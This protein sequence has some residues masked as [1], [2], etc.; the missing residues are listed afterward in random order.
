MSMV[1]TIWSDS[2]GT[3]A[4][5]PTSAEGPCSRGLVITMKPSGE[6]VAGHLKTVGLL[7]LNRYGARRL[8]AAVLAISAP[9]VWHWSGYREFELDDLRWQRNTQPG[10]CLSLKFSLYRPRGRF[11][12]ARLSYQNQARIFLPFFRDQRFSAAFRAISRLW[13]ADKFRARAA[14]PSFPSCCPGVSTGASSRSSSSSPVAIR[15]TLTAPPIT[16]AGRFS[17]RGP[18]GIIQPRLEDEQAILQ[19]PGDIASAA[20]KLSRRFVSVLVD[21]VYF[22]PGLQVD[23]MASQA[24]P[25][26]DPFST[27]II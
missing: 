27:Q 23:Y 15:M 22:V 12:G 2:A 6:V 26:R 3:R 1:D 7:P 13:S 19:R 5:V 17:S 21:G 16:S 18:L 4:S 25:Y 14:P 10:G 20:Q 9:F 11:G 8:A 24:L